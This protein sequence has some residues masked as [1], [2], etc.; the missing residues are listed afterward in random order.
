[1]GLEYQKITLAPSSERGE[2]LNWADKRMSNFLKDGKDFIVLDLG[3]ISHLNRL[4][5]HW[6]GK[7]AKN[8]RNVGGKLNIISPSR[9][10]HRVL[11]R[12]GVN[13]LCG[14]YQTLQAFS[15]AE[16]D[17]EL[18]DDIKPD[19]VHAESHKN[20]GYHENKK[21]WT[22]SAPI[23]FEEEVENVKPAGDPSLTND[24]IEEA[25]VV[26]TDSGNM[27]TDV[28]SLPGSSKDSLENPP[29]ESLEESPEIETEPDQ[30]DKPKDNSEIAV[31]ED[32][33][34]DDSVAKDLIEEE[35][36]LEQVEKSEPIDNGSETNDALKETQILSAE[37]VNVKEQEQ[38]GD[39][40]DPSQIKGVGEV[41]EITGDYACLG[42]GQE[43]PILKGFPFP[44]CFN[45][46]C[47]GPQDGWY[48]VCDIF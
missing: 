42:C 17:V 45:E 40:I 4:D 3:D 14:Y 2:A 28:D 46:N 8:F 25:K 12:S 9:E 19:Y 41:A 32:V 44:E 38:D 6:V 43:E 27:S 10:I 34:I 35:K 31:E 16:S 37:T 15:A 23:H 21:D 1:M 7:W 47:E 39:S 24:R 36:E 33:W 26:D 13:E 48:P 11:E 20:S 18:I 30:L 22:A 5:L 29:E